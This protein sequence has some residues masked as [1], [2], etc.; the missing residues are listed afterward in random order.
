MRVQ[1]GEFWFI[2]G[3]DDTKNKCAPIVV[4]VHEN[5]YMP[6]FDA[7]DYP[8]IHKY[9]ITAEEKK[10]LHANPKWKKQYKLLE[11]QCTKFN[12]KHGLVL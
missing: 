1:I 9:I 10:R 2:M 6:T 5:F 3:A 8:R 7:Y 4:K 12:V 11:G